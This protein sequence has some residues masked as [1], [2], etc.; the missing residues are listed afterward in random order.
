MDN[1]QLDFNDIFNKMQQLYPTQT[2]HA[3]AEVK[4]DM[5]TK[6]LQQEDDAT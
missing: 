2:A 3:V 1:L 6:Q 4:V 5:L